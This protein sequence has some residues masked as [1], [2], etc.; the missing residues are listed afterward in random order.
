MTVPV[1][2]LGHGN[3]F[4]VDARIVSTTPFCHNLPIVVHRAMFVLFTFCP[5]V[6]IEAIECLEIFCSQLFFVERNLFPGGFCILISRYGTMK[7]EPGTPA[8]VPQKENKHVSQ[9]GGWPAWWRDESF[10]CTR[11]ELRFPL[12][13]NCQGI[14]FLHLS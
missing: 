14:I 8:G 2:L 4:P 13:I 5:A 11:I 7:Y 1:T 12:S 6:Q 9:R 3:V 10:V